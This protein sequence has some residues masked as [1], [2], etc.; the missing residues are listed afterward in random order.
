MCNVRV[1]KFMREG[2]AHW[3]YDSPMASRAESVPAEADLLCEGCG[4]VLNGLPG[5]GR[6][7]EC[8]EA[9]AGSTAEGDGR[10]WTVWE[11]GGG[12]A[13][14][15]VRTVWEVV[16]RP[17]GFFRRMRT[18]EEG[19]RSAMFAFG[20]DWVAGWLLAGA[21]A[22]HLMLVV[23][24]MRTDGAGLV[25]LALLGATGGAPVLFAILALTRKLAAWLSVLESRYHGMR[26][27]T[28]AVK[29]AMHYHAAAMIPVA[30]VTLGLTSGLR[31]A[32]GWL[33]G[34]DATAEY[35]WGLSAWVVI[36]AGYLFVTYWAAMKAIMHANR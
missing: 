5:D 7:P 17:G 16:S 23:L 14:R 12:I 11:R 13:G 28:V 6:C 32:L 25:F 26:M 2:A 36:A 19:A 22:Q 10:G 3:A 18:R 15:F 30:A 31:P 9:V 8:G 20:C 27:P 29:R 4:Y 24:G 33:L 21:V 1:Q 34:R 35:L